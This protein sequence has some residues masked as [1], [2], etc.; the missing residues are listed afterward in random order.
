MKITAPVRIDISAGWSDADPF[1]EK[2]GSYVLNAAINLRVF[3]EL[4]EKKLL[5]SL[6][7]VPRKSGLG[8]SGAVRAC[9]LAVS[10][11]RL[12]KNKLDLIRQVWI[13]ENESIKQ[14]A[15]LQDQAAAIFGGVNLWEFGEGVGEKV[16]IKRKKISKKKARH[17]EK[18]LVL[19]YTGSRLSADIHDK[20]FSLNNYKKNVRSIKEMSEIAKKMPGFID[21]ENRIA[22]LINRTWILQKKLHPSI[23]TSKMK[24]LQKKL[25]GAYLACRATGAGGGGCLLF[26]TNKKQ[27]LIKEARK[28]EKKLGVRVINFKFE[29]KGIK[30]EG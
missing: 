7:E 27:K 15:G 17:L 14:R 28:L 12:L 22:G 30:A 3:A 9:Y 4:K 16:K 8:S 21:N 2:Y 26:Y 18:R 11:K 10:N 5:T 1:R 24:K 20:V 25:K 23:E 19:I 29:W 6:N 13:F